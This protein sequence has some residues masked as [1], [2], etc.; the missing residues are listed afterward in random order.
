[1]ADKDTC[2][3]NICDC[4]V[5]DDEDYCSPQCETADAEDLTEMKCDC[6]HS[7]CG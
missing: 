4:T 1:M 2:E 3:H 6:G 7:G 5:G